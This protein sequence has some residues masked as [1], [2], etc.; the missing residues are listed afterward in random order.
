MWCG[1]ETHN[2]VKPNG[3]SVVRDS[4]EQGL[5]RRR[6]QCMDQGASVE[7]VWCNSRG[8]PGMMKCEILEALVGP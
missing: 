4:S 2:Q 5:G 3:A 1:L 7:S 6:Q 8:R